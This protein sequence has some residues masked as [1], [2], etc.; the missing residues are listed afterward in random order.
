MGEANLIIGI[1][2]GIAIGLPI[3]LTT[4]RK[5]KPWSE[6]NDK[7]KRVR[8]GLVAIGT[9]LLIAGIFAFLLLE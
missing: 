3:G 7:E 6:L 4:G 9:T 1:V 5:Q 2:I 8:I